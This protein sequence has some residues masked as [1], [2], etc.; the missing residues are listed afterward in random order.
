M[1]KSIGSFAQD[2]ILTT[3]MSN[4][5]IL[6]AVRKEFPTGKTSMACIAWYKS[7]LRKKGKLEKRGAPKLTVAEK[8]AALQAEIEVLEAQEQE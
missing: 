4:Q 3:P 2:L 8:I 5:E 1:S 7:D 6:E